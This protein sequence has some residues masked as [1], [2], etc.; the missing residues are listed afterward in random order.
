MW[1][2]L[3]KDSM[4]DT[5]MREGRNHLQYLQTGNALRRQLIVVTL[6]CGILGRERTSRHSTTPLK[7][8]HWNSFPTANSHLETPA[9]KYHCGTLSLAH[10]SELSTRTVT[11][12]S[13]C[14]RH[15]PSW[16]QA[17]RTGQCECGTLQRGNACARS[18]VTIKSG[19]W[20]GIRP[21]TEWLPAHKRRCM[22]GTLRLSS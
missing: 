8:V 22:C 20:R 21:A 10:V 17:R 12:S 14:Q 16:H 15:N 5:K 19:L 9:E 4:T 11:R 18:S 6:R 3:T 1:L 2:V 7:Y 13:V